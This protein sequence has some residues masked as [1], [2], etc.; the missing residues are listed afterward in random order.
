[1]T[2]KERKNVQ[3]HSCVLTLALCLMADIFI[4]PLLPLRRPFTT[5]GQLDKEAHGPP[6]LASVRSSNQTSSAPKREFSPCRPPAVIKPWATPPHY[7]GHFQP[8][9]GAC[10]APPRKPQHVS[11][12]AFHTLRAC[13]ASPVLISG[14]SFWCRADSTPLPAIRRHLAQQKRSLSDGGLSSLALA[15]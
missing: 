6:L 15:C 12:K 3:L 8:S 10:P 7:S 1:M 2:E 14:P 11:N 5:S 4:V 13:S 9:L